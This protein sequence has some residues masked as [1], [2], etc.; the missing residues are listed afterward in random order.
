V[1]A[2]LA[3][4]GIPSGPG[5]V[6]PNGTVLGARTTALLTG[7]RLTQIPYT[8]TFTNYGNNDTY[9]VF[10][11]ATY[12]PV[13]ALE[14]TA[15]ARILI[16]DRQS[17]YSSVQPNSVILAALGIRTS[18]LGTANTNGNKFVAEKSFTAILPSDPVVLFGTLGYTMNIGRSVNTRIPPVIIDYVDPGDAV[19]GSDA[20]DR[21]RIWQNGSLVSGARPAPSNPGT[22]PVHRV[23]SGPTP[24]VRS[25]LTHAHR[26]P[27][28]VRSQQERN[29]CGRKD[30]APADGQDP[31][32]A[33]PHRHRR[34][35]YQA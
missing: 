28:P 1:K 18:L 27:G 22:S 5:C 8:S 19:S 26:P 21:H 9:S 17:G 13:P 30:P 32:P 16:E 29:N 20:C 24:R 10:A 6:S 23:V 34:L 11:D 33:V 4:A 25:A 15:G 12:I 2:Q 14:L 7:G 3:A 35:A 31:Q